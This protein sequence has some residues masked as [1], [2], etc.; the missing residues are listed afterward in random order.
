MLQ[1]MTGRWADAY[2]QVRSKRALAELQPCILT[3]FLAI[4]KSKKED[5][6]AE[7]HLESSVHG[8]PL[9]MY[10]RVVE[11]SRPSLDT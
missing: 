4:A 8:I 10:N 9:G 7:Q 2:M 5:S 1:D 11:N 3:H 6:K